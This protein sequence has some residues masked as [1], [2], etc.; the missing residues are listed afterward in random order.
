MRLS[1]KHK[2]NNVQKSR[3]RTVVTM[4][5]GAFHVKETVLVCPREDMIFSSELGSIVPKWC[6][7]GF[8]IIVEVGMS[9]F[10]YCR[11][12]RGWS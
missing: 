6:N 3:K 12:N 9:L 10:V 5:I 1:K 7:I 11:N 8:D 2:E 4:D